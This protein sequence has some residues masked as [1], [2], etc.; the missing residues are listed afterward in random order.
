M[1]D[2]TILGTGGSIPMPNRHLASAI[3]KYK[4]RK[5]LIDCGEGTQVSMRKN[6]IGFKTIDIICITHYHGDHIIG[7]PGLLSTIGNSGREEPLTIIGPEGI[8]DI[9]KGLLVITPYL[10]Y[11]LRIIENPQSTIEIDNSYF[12]KE[13]L[14]H[15]MKLDHSSPC[16]GYKFELKRT[17][18][19]SIEKATINNVPKILWNKLQKQNDK[20]EYE[21]KTYIKDMVL[22]EDR[23]GIGISY[24]TDTIFFEDIIPFIKGSDLFICE[25][26]YGSEEDKEKAIQNKHM[27]FKEAATL[28]LKGEVETLILTHFSATMGNPLEFIDNAKNIFNNSIVGYD[29]YS[30]TINFK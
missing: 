21:G 12:N 27:T 30:I 3:I 24:I 28:A 5:I 13:I 7:L 14:I 2:I 17:P 22:G 29:G 15:T 23:K 10:P 16:I 18:K 20:I 26:N 6:N 19:F 9:L 25:G 8:S 1:I 4:G 11:E